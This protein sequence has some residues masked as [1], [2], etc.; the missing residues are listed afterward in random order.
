MHV[1]ESST[2][3]FR[4]FID[5]QEYWQG[6]KWGVLEPLEPLPGYPTGLGTNLKQINEKKE[7]FDGKNEHL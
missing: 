6:V 1:I 3:E 4:S 2:L 5:Q 7:S